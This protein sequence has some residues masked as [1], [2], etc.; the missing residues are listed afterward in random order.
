MI[1]NFRTFVVLFFAL[2]LSGFAS[3][4]TTFQLRYKGYALGAHAIDMDIE[5][6]I[7]PTSYLFRS[8]TR[9]VG[10]ADMLAR[11]RVVDTATGIIGPQGLQLQTYVHDEQ[12][13][14]V[15]TS[16]QGTQ[17]TRRVPDGS[18][19][20]TNLVDEAVGAL[21]VGSG[22]LQA[23]YMISQSGSCNG[24]FRLTDG[25]TVGEAVSRNAGLVTLPQRGRQRFGGQAL[26]CQISTRTLVNKPLNI[27]NIEMWMSPMGNSGI[28][29]PIKMNWTLE[30]QVVEMYLDAMSVQ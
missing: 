14:S 27:T 8:S 13:K 16:I 1:R 18:V 24:S 30:G 23:A 26:L 29:M 7:A 4:Q 25:S 12:H 22:I 6:Q 28:Y 9:T 10:L 15:T 3:A 11:R 20:T 19:T 2:T 5:A 17:R 21:D